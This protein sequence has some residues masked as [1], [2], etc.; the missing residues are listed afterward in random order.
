MKAIVLRQLI[1]DIPD[2]H[3]IVF[4][5]ETGIEYKLD[6]DAYIHLPEYETVYLGESRESL[7]HEIMSSLSDDEKDIRARFDE[8]WDS[9]EVDGDE[10]CAVEGSDLPIRTKV[11][12]VPDP[13]KDLESEEVCEPL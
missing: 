6:E 8:E 5:D 7:M 1:H 9:R 3:D 2:D 11:C 4:M 10:S 12:V 13:H